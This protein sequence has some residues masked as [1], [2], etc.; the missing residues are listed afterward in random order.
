[1][2]QVGEK[3]RREVACGDVRV[4]RRGSVHLLSVQQYLDHLS[5]EQSISFN[6]INKI[7]AAPLSINLRVKGVRSKTEFHLKALEEEKGAISRLVPIL[8]PH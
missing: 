1:M 7:W 8:S 4:R 3:V 6:F 5:T 2:G